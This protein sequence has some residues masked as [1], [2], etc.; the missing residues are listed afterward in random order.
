M[1]LKPFYNQMVKIV[2]MNDVEYH[3]TV[4]G[5]IEPDNNASKESIV[6]DTLE[7]RAI[8]FYDKDLKAIEIVSKFGDDATK[9]YAQ[10]RLEKAVIRV[11][12]GKRTPE[13][14]QAEIEKAT[15]EFLRNVERQR[16][17]QNAGKAIQND[18]SPKGN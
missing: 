11:H 2:D 15:I 16:K 4:N 17:R 6:L 9:G 3:G 5:Y 8:E 7:G 18:G 14:R 1:S 12:P 10:Y 13:E